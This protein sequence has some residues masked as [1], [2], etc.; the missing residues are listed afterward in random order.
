MFG[1]LEHVIVPK[2]GQGDVEPFHDKVEDKYVHKYKFVLGSNSLARNINSF[3]FKKK[4]V[5]QFLALNS[6]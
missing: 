6:F 2:I 5:T 3:F 1:P 4:I